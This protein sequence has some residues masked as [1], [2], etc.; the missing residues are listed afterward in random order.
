MQGVES[1][2]RLVQK[3]KSVVLDLLKEKKKNLETCSLPGHN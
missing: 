1:R 2:T 3:R